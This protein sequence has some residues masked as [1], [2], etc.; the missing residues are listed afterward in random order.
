MYEGQGE[1]VPVHGFGN[2][3]Y[4]G[5]VAPQPVNVNNGKMFVKFTTNSIINRVGFSAKYSVG[6]YSLKVTHHS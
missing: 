5:T 3:G 2:D 6:R 1:G 4:S